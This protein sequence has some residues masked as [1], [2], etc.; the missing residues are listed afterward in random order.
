MKTD[1]LATNKLIVSYDYHAAGE[2]LLVLTGSPSFSPSIPAA[3]P[4]LMAI[5]IIKRYKN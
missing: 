3:L 5:S 4:F 2:K 1:E